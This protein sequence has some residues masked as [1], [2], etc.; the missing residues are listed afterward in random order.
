[1]SEV[2][3]IIRKAENTIVQALKADGWEL[4]YQDTDTMML[5]KGIVKM[6]MKVVYQVL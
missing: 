1:M 4:W 3:D 6:A 5:S 2:V